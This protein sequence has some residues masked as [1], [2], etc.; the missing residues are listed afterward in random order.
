MKKYFYLFLLATCSLLTV[1]CSVNP[2]SGKKQLSFMSET[3]ELAIGKENDPAVIAQFGLYPNDTI[4]QFIKEKGNQMAAK[5]HRPTLPFEFRVLDSDVINAFAVPGGYVYFTRGILAHF[6]NEAQF[7]G[8]LGH[9]IGHITARHSSQQYTK[10]ML[11]QIAFM[12]GMLLSEKFRNISEQAMQGMQLMFLK[13]SRDDESESDVL[14]VKYSSAIGYDAK[15]MADFFKT[16]QRVTEKDGARLPEFMSTHPDP[17]N[18]YNDVMKLATEYQTTNNLSGLKINR[19][20]YLKMIDG[21]VYGPDPRQGYL[22]K[23]NSIFYQP[24]MKFEYPIP[25]DWQF[26]NSPQAVQAAPKEGDAA[27]ILMLSSQNNFQDASAEMLEAYNLKLVANPISSKINNIDA[28]TFIAEQKQES[29]QYY[30]QQQPTQQTQ[31]T[32]ENLLVHTT[33]YRYDGNIYILHGMCAKK[34]YAKYKNTFTYSMNGFKAL[35][36]PK[37]INVVPER[38]QIVALKNDAT[39]KEVMIANKIPADRFEEVAILNGMQQNTI[40][41][42]GT[43]VKMLEKKL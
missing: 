15:E 3:Q 8:V 38:I 1:S 33:L 25:R 28:Y 19:D 29:N 21:I 4:Q 37:R 23:S 16:L 36:D 22:D 11:T 6:N 17:G 12:G 18:R 27:L 42:K 26:Q 14:G 41:K 20:A 31:N 5:S 2:V 7:A 24:E 10:Q 9:E 30:G 32:D 40:V 35:T 43:L 34:D 39:L 13:F